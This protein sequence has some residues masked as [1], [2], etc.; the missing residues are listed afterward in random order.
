L[1]N[2]L[3]SIVSLRVAVVGCGRWGSHHLAA[4]VRLQDQLNIEHI[5]ACDTDLDV[6]QSLRLSGFC[7]HENVESLV[8]EHQV[9][10]VI[11]A[12]PNNTHYALG[13]MFL[14]Q[15]VHA[16][17]EKPLSVEHDL[18]SSLVSISVEKGKVLKTGFLL[19]FHPCV[20][21]LHSRIRSGELGAIERIEYRRLSTR[22]G[23]PDSNCLDSLAIHGLDIAT[24]LL[25]E[26][27]PKAISSVRG[28]ERHSQLSLEF[29]YQVEVEIEVGWGNE[30]DIAE[31]SLHG[32]NGI[33]LVRLN[34][35]DSYTILRDGSD[36]PVLVD[37]D[38]TPLDGQLVDF[39]TFDSK[40]TSAAS[41]GSILRTIDCIEQA[42]LKMASQGVKTARE[43]KR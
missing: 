12:T 36:V 26:Q 35:H 9:D 31:F 22:E 32:S 38:Q 11:V 30:Y 21:D 13:K 40:T 37:S 17:V 19:R 18:A 10:A 34:Q 20:Q 1:L 33:A 39:L 14:E 27:S 4:L 23:D 2:G 24:L 29:P 6:A 3:A 15:G 8:E 28:N 16:L 25:S 43:L 41:T 5:V 7:V 42:R